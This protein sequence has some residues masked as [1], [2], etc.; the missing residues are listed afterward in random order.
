[1]NI[2]NIIQN[3]AIEA[4]QDLYGVCVEASLVQVQQTKKEFSG[5]VTLVIF[6]LLKISL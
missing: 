1:M 2:E 4:I 5:D 3:K 6:P